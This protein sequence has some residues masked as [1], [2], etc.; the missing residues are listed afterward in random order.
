MEICTLFSQII[1]TSTMRNQYLQL[2]QIYP[3]NISYFVLLLINV[4]VTSYMHTW[5][6]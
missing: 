6:Q 3:I 5:Q 1:I 2:H 4:H